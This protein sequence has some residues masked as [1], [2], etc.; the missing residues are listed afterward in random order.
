MTSIAWYGTGPVFKN[1]A[2]GTGS[3]CCGGLF[4]CSA[5]S[6]EGTPETLTVVVSNC[7]YS[8]TSFDPNGTYV[9]NRIAGYQSLQYPSDPCFYWEYTESPGCYTYDPSVGPFFGN[10]DYK[11]HI[12][13]RRDAGY[14]QVSITFTEPEPGYDDVTC[15]PCS[16]GVV[17]TGTQDNRLC[18]LPFSETM[19]SQYFSCEVVVSE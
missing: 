7:T 17:G 10:S 2:V 19:T 12:Y 11:I 3:A 5:C 6:G 16:G 8:P 18:G 1:G 14:D 15:E 4:C 9:L 13:V